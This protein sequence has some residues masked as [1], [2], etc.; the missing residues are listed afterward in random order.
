MLVQYYKATKHL[1]RDV[2]AS[3]AYIR[4]LLGY[5][6]LC[7]ASASTSASDAWNGVSQAAGSQ[8]PDN[9]GHIM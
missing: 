8:D 4:T 2:M 6:L 1:F 3:H 9:R 7:P 5:T